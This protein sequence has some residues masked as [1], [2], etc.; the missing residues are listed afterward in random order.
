M[1]RLSFA[2]LALC[3]TLM[4]GCAHQRNDTARTEYQRTETTRTQEGNAEGT[5][6]KSGDHSTQSETIRTHRESTTTKESE[7]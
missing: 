4:V 2:T 7:K 1:I 5:E 6:M 3:L